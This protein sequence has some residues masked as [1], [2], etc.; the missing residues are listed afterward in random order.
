VGRDTQIGDSRDFAPLLLGERHLPSVYLAS[1]YPEDRI[2]SDRDSL[3]D[4]P[5]L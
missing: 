1:P 4:Y 3:G 2:I 5:E